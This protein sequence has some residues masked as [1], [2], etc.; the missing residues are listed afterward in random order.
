MFLLDYEHEKKQKAKRI[1]LEDSVNLGAIVLNN[2]LLFFLELRV[3]DLRHDKVSSLA[4]V[5]KNKNKQAN[6]S[7]GPAFYIIRQ[8]HPC[9]KIQ[10]LP[11]QK[12]NLQNRTKVNFLLLETYSSFVK[13]TVIAEE[14]GLNNIKPTNKKQFCHP[15]PFEHFCPTHCS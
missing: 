8:W 2:K 10:N 11:H 12:L 6:K 13:N 3:E 1:N 14:T 15:A 4:H 9:P 7:V 5:K